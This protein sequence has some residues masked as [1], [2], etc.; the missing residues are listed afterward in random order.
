MSRFPFP[1]VFNGW[2]FVAY[3]DE[4]TRQR[5]L[6][7][8]YFGGE[9]V[10]F[11]DDDGV[12]HVLDAH[13]PHLGAHLG[14]GGSVVGRTVQCPFHGWRFDGAGACV[15]LGNGDK[16]PPRASLRSWPTREVNGMVLVYY[17]AHGDAPAW[18][19]PSLPE[20]GSPDYHPY[21]KRS[22]TVRTHI[23]EIA[24]N[25]TDGAHFR[26][27]HESVTT[28]TVEVTTQGHV[29]RS[30]LMMQQS[31]PRGPV[32]ACIDATL[33]GLGFWT[34][35]LRGIID[36]TIVH[37]TT[38][39]DDEW[40]DVRFS[41]LITRAGGVHPSSGVAKALIADTCHQLSQDIVIW[42]HKTYRERPALA[43]GDGTIMRL[44]R[45]ARQFH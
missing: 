34:I 17:H 20:H 36:V 35:R 27:I 43:T 2:Y 18:E 26:E 31:T 5:V 22:W 12:V 28:P 25:I 3:A 24:E 4:L 37:T 21:V 8:R 32:D 13:C 44:R 14:Y 7:L 41:Y 45:W 16:A 19:V 30:V 38:P 33:H 1:T 11:R 23:Q 9:L 40:V 15:A 10:A 42:E 29:L 6:P 39:I